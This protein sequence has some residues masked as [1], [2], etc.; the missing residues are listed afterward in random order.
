MGF[1]RNKNTETPVQNKL[2]QERKKTT[3]V[4]YWAGVGSRETPDDICKAMGRIGACFL[5]KRWTCRSGDATGADKAWLS[6]SNKT[7]YMENYL[8]YEKGSQVKSP[9]LF[10]DLESQKEALKISSYYHKIGFLW[11][12]GELT[13]LNDKQKT[14]ALLMGRNASQVL[15]DDLKKPAAFVACWTPEY[16]I[17]ER[18]LVCDGSGGTGLAIRLAYD[19]KIP[20][21]HMGI[22]KHREILEALCDPSVQSF[23]VVKA[24]FE[25][26]NFPF[27]AINH[28]LIEERER[29]KNSTQVDEENNTTYLE[30]SSFVDREKEEIKQPKKKRTLNFENNTEVKKEDRNNNSL[31]NSC[32]L[33]NSIEKNDIKPLESPKKTRK[34][35]FPS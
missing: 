9:I 24:F 23:E 35:I 7:D 22:K 33:E 8:A 29:F 27:S 25:K 13:G 4:L 34:I 19:K 26:N 14:V 2:K 3:P 30:H 1:S 11:R 6:Q 20:V 32:S 10:S 16:T 31:T 15:G 18:G 12:S 21:L 28:F 5:E 17:D